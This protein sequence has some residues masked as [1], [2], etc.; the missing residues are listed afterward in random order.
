MSLSLHTL[1]PS[2]H[3]KKD[4]KYIGRGLGSK[5]TY[6]GRG[7]KGQGARSGV[8]GLKLK[9]MR[10]IIL[11]TPKLRGFKS[12]NPKAQ[13]LN[14]DVLSKAFPEGGKIT[15]KQLVAKKLI[16]DAMAVTKILGNGTVTAKFIL[17]GC[18]VSASAKEK[19][20]QAGGSV[21]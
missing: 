4:R 11:S 6:S 14:L 19:I 8:S 1:K 12:K 18:L 15:P 3:S 13:V 10:K 20:E 17:K 7:V 16:L 21:V 9:G 2:P 5:G